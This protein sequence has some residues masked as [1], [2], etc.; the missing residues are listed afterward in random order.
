MRRVHPAERKQEN[1]RTERDRV[2]Y[3][4]S[5]GHQFVVSLYLR[6]QSLVFIYRET[7]LEKQRF[8]IRESN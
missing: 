7:M 5:A 3:E 8:S 6:V 2:K 1:R 4:N